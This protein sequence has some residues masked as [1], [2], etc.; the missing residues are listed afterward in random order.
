MPWFSRKWKL[1]M[2]ISGGQTGVDQAAL[3]AAKS[4]GIRTG[5][6]APRGFL[7]EAGYMPELEELYGMVE[8]HSEFYQIRTYNNVEY[9]DGTIRIAHNFDSPGEKCTL[10]AITLNNKPYFDIDLK[11][12]DEFLDEAIKW[13]TDNKI[14]VLNVSGNRESTYSGIGVLSDQLLYSLFSKLV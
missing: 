10:K 7:T 2:V 9:S 11:T 12:D 1:K 3:R 5:G 6:Y 4:V 14:E 8:T 13:L